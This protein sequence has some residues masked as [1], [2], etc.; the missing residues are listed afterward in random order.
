MSSGWSEWGPPYP[1]LQRASHEGERK[2]YAF[3][4]K[5]FEIAEGEDGNY[6]DVASPLTEAID[7]YGNVVDL[8]KEMGQIEAEERVGSYR[9]VVS[10]VSGALVSFAT[11][12]QSTRLADWRQQVIS[13]SS[14][15]NDRRI[16][17]LEIATQ[18][19]ESLEN[20]RRMISELSPNNPQ[21]FRDVLLT[22]GLSM[23]LGASA[24][25][26]LE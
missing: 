1:V 19:K 4:R 6:Q 22:I 10:Q 18:A 20:I 23:A 15:E 21:K 14:V 7:L 12:N 5:F 25:S 26:L 2:F 3:L 16:D 9:S 17:H 13:H 8:S 24:S 11:L